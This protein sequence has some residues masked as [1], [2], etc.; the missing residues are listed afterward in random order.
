VVKNLSCNAEDMGSVPDGGTEILHAMG[1]ISLCTTTGESVHHSER[2][3]VMQ[4]R[5]HMPQ[6][7]PNIA[8]QR[9]NFKKPNK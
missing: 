2:F 6:V 8:K 4:P 7:R 3:Y 1:Q 9:N 5:S